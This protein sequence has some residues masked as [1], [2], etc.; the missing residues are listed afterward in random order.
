[1][2]YN[3]EFVA[4]Q[5]EIYLNLFPAPA[6]VINGEGELVLVNNRWR[7]TPHENDFFGRDKTEGNYFDICTKSIESGSDFGLKLLLGLRNVMDGEREN[8]SLDIPL[9]QN[10]NQNWYKIHIK[11][12][13]DDSVAILFEEITQHVQA[14]RALRDSEERYKQQFEH[15]LNG[16]IIGTPDGEIKDVNP[17]ACDILGYTREELIKGGRSLVVDMDQPV[18]KKAWE[19]R[20]E[21]SKFVGEKEYIH[22]SGKRLYA[23]VTS[24][25]YRNADGELTTINSFQDITKKKEIEKSLQ[26]ERKFI[27]ASMESV[28]GTFFVIDE[29]RKMVRWNNAVHNDL[30]ITQEMIDSMKVE[31]FICEEDRANVM[32]ALQKA[33]EFGEA[34]IIAGLHTAENGVRQYQLNGKK[35]TTENGTYIVG[36]GVD[37][38]DLLEAEKAREENFKM[39]DQLFD[40]SPLGIVMINQENRV[41]RVNDGFIN[42]FGYSKEEV[43][44]SNV[45]EL[46]ARDEQIREA[47][48]VSSSAFQ[49]DTEQVESVRYTKSG[50]KVPVLVNTVP[51][52]NN[53]D[54]IAVYGIYVDLTRQKTMEDKIKELLE[55]EKEAREKVQ[56]S[57]DEKEVLLQEVHHRVKNNL[58]VIAGIIDLQLME[59]GKTE[60]A[61]KLGEVQSRIFSISKIHETLYQEKNVVSIQFDQYLKAFIH[62]LPQ[63]GMDHKKATDITLETDEIVLNL[64]QAVPFGLMLNEILNIVFEEIEDDCDTETLLKVSEV[65]GTV[66]FTLFGECLNI[67]RLYKNRKSEKF[68]FKLIDILLD[69]LHANM[70]LNRNKKQLTVNFDKMSLRGSSSSLIEEEGKVY[71]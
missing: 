43:I 41:S 53:G 54:V 31:E 22:K 26:D 55:L 20:Q 58:A 63:L 19:V 64:N 56:V 50:K 17:A 61:H 40:K 38:T 12:V 5:E 29:N 39:L 35:F 57:L 44:Q 7:E 6:G 16:I 67:D 21:K 27:N 4:K 33:Y 30:G 51:V 48:C 49:G 1:M 2:D 10:G 68:Q 9:R 32:E 14:R 37:V 66:S 62:S 13:N 34:S 70:E 59:E 60:V 25:M 15:S 42:L 11:P 8:F 46:I 3:K 23:H 71:E 18:N 45:N 24:M 52:R 47:N 65:E 36:T 28:P 69:Q